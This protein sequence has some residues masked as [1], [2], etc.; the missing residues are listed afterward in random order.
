LKQLNPAVRC[1]SLQPD[2]A[3]HG[4]EGWKHMATAIVP[5]IYDPSVADENLPVPT[6]DGYAL[7]KRLASE[8]GLLVSP[9]AGAALAGCFAVARALPR[10]ERAVIVTVFPD[11]ADKYLSERFWEES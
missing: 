8:E 2:S 3:F 11:A 7:A 5:A 9:S 10:E 6:E 4:L 1:I